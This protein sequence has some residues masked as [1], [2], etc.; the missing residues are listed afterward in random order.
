LRHPARVESV[1]TTA[2]GFTIRGAGLILRTRRLI[3]ATGGTALP[4]S[5]SDGHGYHIA[6]SLGHTTTRIFPALVPLVLNRDCPLRALAG[7]TLPV[8]VELRSGTSRRLVAFTDSTLCTHFGLSGPAV[9]DISRHYLDA[10]HT[11]PGAHLVASFLPDTER[12]HM[13]KE[14]LDLG[15]H[16]VTTR[17][18]AMLPVRLADAL[19]AHAGVMPET[20]GASL[21]KDTRRALL[22]AVLDFRLPVTGD[23]GFTH[24]EV[25]AGGVPLDEI[26]TKTMGSRRC[27]GLHLCGEILDADGRIGGYNFQWAWAS[28]HIAGLSAAQSLHG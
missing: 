14:L 23:R 25:T 17:L 22:D 26:D 6:R 24:A 3:L 5:G 13:E 2:A 12:H 19:C 4:K 27:P 10:R 1:E 8:R 28:G 9:M 21:R 18:R 7:L 16:R 20:T 11:D 15:P